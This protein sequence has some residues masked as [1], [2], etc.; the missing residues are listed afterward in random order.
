[1]SE[2][3]GKPIDRVDGRL[4]VTGKAQYSAEFALPNL[5]HAVV[6]QSTI[7]KGRINNMNTAKA[8]SS[9]GVIKVINFRNALSLHFPSSSS[10]DA[11]KYGEK[12]LLPL[13][14]DRIF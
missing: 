7:A 1:M 4:K 14:S 13:Q 3:I 10:P 12:D 8:E 2:Q 5:V 6:V 9:P 11:G